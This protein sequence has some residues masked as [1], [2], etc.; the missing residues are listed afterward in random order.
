MSSSLANIAKIP[1]LKKRIFFTLIML[2]VYR[3]FVFVPTPGINLDALKEV[4]A[5]GSIFDLMNM[6]S[7][8]ALSNFSV[9]ALGIMPYITSSIIFS[10]LTVAVPAIERLSKEG[11]QG[12]KKISQYSRYGTV[13]VC[14]IQGMG[15]SFGLEKQH[16]LLPGVGGVSFYT[17]TILTLAAGTCF[18]MWIGEQITERGIGNGISLIIFSGI[19]SRI[20]EGMRDVFI[21]YSQLGSFGIIFVLIFIFLIAYV[22]IFFERSQRRIPIQ[23][24]KRVVGRRVFAQQTNHLP[25]KLN[26][27]GVIPPIFASSLLSFPVTIASFSDNS[28]VKA[29]AANLSNGPLHYLFYGSLI[30]FFCYFYASVT[31]NPGTMAENVQKAGGFIPGIRPG[32][33]TSEFIEKVITRITLVGG[34]YI[35]AICLLPNVLSDYFKLPGTIA[36]TFGG[37]SVLIL[38]GVAMDTVA[39][40]ESYL[41]SRNY[42]GFLGAKSGRFKGRR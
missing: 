28:T 14:L 27:T 9:L 18:A 36:Y 41:L 8:G 4:L 3:I 25:L 24:A 31:F 40:A 5:P 6:F 37:T 33:P 15:I 39:Q 35:T 22:I 11:D 29:I 19:V 16:Y 10:L 21:M 12:R 32:K 30:I 23:Y 26:L 2:V 1:E 13:L 42:D 17:M 20:P 34:I 7:G 38:I